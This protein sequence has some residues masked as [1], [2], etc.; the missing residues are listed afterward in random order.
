MKCR[1]LRDVEDQ[2][3]WHPKGE[4]IEF[5][6]E[7]RDAFWV[8]TGH[9]SGM[10]LTKGVD[11]EAVKSINVGDRVRQKVWI[12][13]EVVG[14]GDNQSQV[15]WN[16]GRVSGFLPDEWLELIEAHVRTEE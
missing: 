13:G 11:A 8:T 5:D 14:G 12:E 7:Y 10:H 4:V 9:G 15:L 3:I 1:L 6:K 16:D 2:G